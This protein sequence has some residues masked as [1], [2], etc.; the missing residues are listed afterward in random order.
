MSHGSGTRETEA[1]RP[2]VC[3]CVWLVC[4]EGVCVCACVCVCDAWVR[5]H[6]GE[7]AHPSP[8]APPILKSP[9]APSLSSTRSL[10]V[11]FCRLYLTATTWCVS[12]FSGA[13]VIND[14]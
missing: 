11:L 14:Y 8:Q 5:K 12:V 6:E 10:L 2:R 1:R 9:P 7:R 3:V 13:V 4:S